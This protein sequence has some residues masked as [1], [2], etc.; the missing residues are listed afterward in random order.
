MLTRSPVPAAARH[1]RGET[2]AVPPSSGSEMHRRQGQR[3]HT[4]IRVSVSRDT[5]QT[6]VLRCR[7]SALS[8]FQIVKAPNIAVLQHPAERNARMQCCNTTLN[9]CKGTETQQILPPPQTNDR[10]TTAYL[11][12][13][14]GS[15]VSL[16]TSPA[17]SQR[18]HRNSVASVFRMVLLTRHES[19]YGCDS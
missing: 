13:T 1:C 18:T 7:K 4:A 19:H 8:T 5:T 12:Q 9:T 14:A 10:G 3:R 16:L 17:I 6:T 15:D 11:A 2:R